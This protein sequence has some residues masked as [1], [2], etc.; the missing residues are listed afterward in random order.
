MTRKISTYWYDAIDTEHTITVDV[1]A[2]GLS[3][4][5]TEDLPDM[6][7]DE[8]CRLRERLAALYWAAE[9]HD[10]ECRECAQEDAGER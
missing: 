1:W 7:G 3:D 8:E 5:D 9:S 4:I 6:P 10:F 2:D